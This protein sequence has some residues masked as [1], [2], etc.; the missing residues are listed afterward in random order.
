MENRVFSCF[1]FSIRD[2]THMSL[3]FYFFFLSPSIIPLY[4]TLVYYNVWLGNVKKICFSYS[5]LFLAHQKVVCELQE[6]IFLPILSIFSSHISSLFLSAFE[7]EVPLGRKKI[8]KIR[9]F[10]EVRVLWCQ[11]M[12]SNCVLVCIQGVNYKQSR[13]K[14][15]EKRPLLFTFFMYKDTKFKF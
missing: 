15:A 13:E 8:W 14:K 3:S 5:F 12:Y 11:H 6:F 9:K 1:I 10:Q 7:Q 4:P 2:F